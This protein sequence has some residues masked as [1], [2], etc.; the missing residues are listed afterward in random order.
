[1]TYNLLQNVDF[2]EKHTLL[3]LVHVALSQNLD[4]SLSIGLSVNAHADLSKGT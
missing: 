2:V 4:S 1:M 3:I